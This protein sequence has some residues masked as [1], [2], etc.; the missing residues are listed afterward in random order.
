MDGKDNDLN[1]E[2]RRLRLR[3]FVLRSAFGVFRSVQMNVGCVA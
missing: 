3:F 2:G 1:T